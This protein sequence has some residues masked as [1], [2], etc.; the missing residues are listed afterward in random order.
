MSKSEEIR[1]GLRERRVPQVL[2][3]AIEA[4]KQEEARKA[5]ERE[6]ESRDTS[7]D[8]SSDTSRDGL[9]DASGDLS[10]DTSGDKL[11][12]GTAAEPQAAR[13]VPPVGGR[14][15]PR[16]EQAKRTFYMPPDLLAAWEKYRKKRENRG[17]VVSLQDTLERLLRNHLNT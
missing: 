12:K 16:R 15:V 1:K 4:G 7:G 2:Q 10:R 11:A 13:N 3:E 14:Y 9:H 5:A 6:A 17:A 8:L